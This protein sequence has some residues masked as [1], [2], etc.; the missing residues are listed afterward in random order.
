MALTTDRDLPSKAPGI[1]RANTRYVLLSA[2]RRHLSIAGHH[3][4]GMAQRTLSSI[5]PKRDR[6]LSP[7]Q[8]AK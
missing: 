6:L 3:C 5:R 1:S 4:C 8:L 7:S 2:I